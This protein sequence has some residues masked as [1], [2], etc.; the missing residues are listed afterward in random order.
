M[1]GLASRRRFLTLAA[2]GAVTT[3]AGCSSGS[4]ATTT[5]T[6]TA[7]ADT[8]PSAGP[9]GSAPRP[10]TPQES[11]KALMDGNAR[12][13]AGPF[14]MTRPDQTVEVRADLASGQR[15][16]AVVL[17][18][19]DSRVPP[20][21]LFDQGLG[22]LFV[23]RVAGNVTDPAVIGSI[24]YAV[25]HLTP[26]PGVVMVMGHQR[27]GAVSAAV[28]ALQ[29]DPSVDPHA[30]HNDAD[31]DEIDWLINAITPAAQA[32]KPADPIDKTA[33]D[34][35]VA[36]AI[37]ENVRMARANLLAHA[38]LKTPTDSGALLIVPAVYALDTGAVT[39]LD[40]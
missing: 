10:T 19:S 1:S 22:D 36:A 31:P 8:A 30:G 5:V 4:A 15:P 24:E 38:P 27:C 14:E 2:A 33:W 6:V 35:W 11:L 26:A 9:S 28:S 32:T 12:F 40:A 18:C 37:A 16:F 39:L 7:P 20:E 34:A 17:T 25:E 13:V 3:I 29:A 23:V 21:V